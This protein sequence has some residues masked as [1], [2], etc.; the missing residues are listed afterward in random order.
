MRTVRIKTREGVSIEATRQAE[1]H[2]FACRYELPGQCH[3]MLNITA[4]TWGDARQ[5]LVDL[6]G[7]FDLEATQE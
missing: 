6:F 2:G 7:A 4:A 3:G 1:P 5:K